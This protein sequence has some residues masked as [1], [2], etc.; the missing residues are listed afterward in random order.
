[1]NKH[2]KLVE[3]SC[4]EETFQPLEFQQGTLQALKEYKF[5]T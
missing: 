4:F 5:A 3:G 2:V 1:M